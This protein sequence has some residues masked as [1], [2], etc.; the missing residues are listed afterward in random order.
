MFNKIKEFIL[1]KR[2]KDAELA[3]AFG[4]IIEGQERSNAHIVAL[5]RLMFIK[6]SVWVREA[7][8]TKAN[9]DY[10]LKMIEELELQTKETK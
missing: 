3:Q 9:T 7:Q 4:V 8:N 10:L 5:A 6:S 2:N 1:S